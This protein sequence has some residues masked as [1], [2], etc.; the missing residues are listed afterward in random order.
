MP[1]WAWIVI[2]VGV[3]LVV[4]VAVVARW[5]IARRRRTA[6]LRG[7]FG[8]EYDVTLRRHES[9]G[10][11]EA[12]LSERLRRR[13]QLQ[14]RSLDAKTRE[15]YRQAWSDTQA[16][17]VEAPEAAAASAHSLVRS[18]M[19]DRGYPMENLE[20]RV[21]DISVDHPIVVE[22]YRLAQA[23]AVKAA[24]GEAST[25][26]LRQ[27]MHHYRV[28]FDELLE[29]RAVGRTRHEAEALTEEEVTR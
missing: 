5:L 13:D 8:P 3:V 26:E 10:E 7:R 24:R 21:A 29:T 20:Q 1:V 27:A 15:R 19:A 28:L 4:V 2:A 14:I 9:R 17:F 12:E 6:F 23:T 16:Q 11:A 22:N 25:E 18:V